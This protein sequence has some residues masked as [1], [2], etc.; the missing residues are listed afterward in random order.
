MRAIAGLGDRERGALGR[1]APDFD[2]IEAAACPGD[3]AGILAIANNRGSATVIGELSKLKPVN[4]TGAGPETAENGQVGI[5]GTILAMVAGNHTRCQET[6]ALEGAENRASL[7]SSGTLTCQPAK[8]H[9]KKEAQKLTEIGQ[10][11]ASLAMVAG[12][13][14]YR[15]RHSLQVAV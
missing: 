7:I 5:A 12:A 4:E 3:L 9:S 14:N 2:E 15:H 11:W 13:R 6:K 10:P 1:D 8:D